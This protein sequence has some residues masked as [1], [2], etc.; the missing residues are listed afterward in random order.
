MWTK[1]SHLLWGLFDNCIMGFLRNGFGGLS[2]WWVGICKRISKPAH[3]IC[4]GCQSALSLAVTEENCHCPAAYIISNK[5][6]L[7]HESFYKPQDTCRDAGGFCSILPA[8]PGLQ[9]LPDSTLAAAFRRWALCVVI[10]S[11]SWSRDEENLFPVLQ[12]WASELDMEMSRFAHICKTCLVI[13]VLLEHICVCGRHWK[14]LALLSSFLGNIT[15][16]FPV[17]FSPECPVRYKQV[18]RW[19]FKSWLCW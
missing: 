2:P 3:V 16:I 14:L 4:L 12:I 19:R 9:R 15:L 1:H 10:N 8:F 7:L 11:L 17:P 13:S 6:V 18:F 5:L